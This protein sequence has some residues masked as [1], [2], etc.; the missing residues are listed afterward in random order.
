MNWKIVVGCLMCV[1]IGIC[2]GY[3]HYDFE[4]IIIV[5]T[6]WLALEILSQGVEE[7]RKK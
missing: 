4:L 7:M 6:I 5:S 3:G 2:V 1:V